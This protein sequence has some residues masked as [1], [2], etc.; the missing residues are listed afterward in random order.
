MSH[1]IS[2]EGTI[3]FNGFPGPLAQSAPAFPDF[4]L[5]LCLLSCS[6]VLAEAESLAA[7]LITS[8]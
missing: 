4:V 7:E 8:V 5:V 2:H 3:Y 6:I 1:L